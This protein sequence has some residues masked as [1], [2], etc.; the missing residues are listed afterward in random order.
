MTFQIV[1]DFHLQHQRLRNGPLFEYP[2][3]YKK[4]DPNCS[5]KAPNKTYVTLRLRLWSQKYRTPSDFVPFFVPTTILE[6]MPSRRLT[7]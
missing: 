5:A 1:W 6:K 4:F 2:P 3:V 7:Y